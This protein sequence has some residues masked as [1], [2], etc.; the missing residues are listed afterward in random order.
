MRVLMALDAL[1]C[2]W[3]VKRTSLAGVLNP[4]VALEAIDPL[5]YVGSMFELPFLRVLLDSE[6]FGARSRK[7]GEGYE[8]DDGDDPAGHFFDHS[9]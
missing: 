6:H 8:Y 5:E 7:A 1:L 2:G 9:L 4:S 3:Q